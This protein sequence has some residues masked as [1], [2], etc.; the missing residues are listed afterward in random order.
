MVSFWPPSPQCKNKEDQRPL[1]WWLCPHSIHGI[2]PPYHC[3]HVYWSI[4]PVCPISLGKTEVLFQASYPTTNH[5]PSIRETELKTVKGFTYLRSVI[6]N[7]DSLGKEINTRVCKVSKQQT[8]STQSVS[9]PSSRSTRPSHSHQHSV[10]FRPW[11]EGMSN[12]GSTFTCRA[13]AL[14]WTSNGRIGSQ[15]LRSWPLEKLLILKPWSWKPIIDAWMDYDRIQKQLLYDKLSKVK[16][17][18][19]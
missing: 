5:H 15:N 19:W 9:S 7:D 13:C 10:R 3:Q 4:L 1:S 16:V 2:Y 17:K 12:S 18:A 8:S 11:I 14:S 6:S